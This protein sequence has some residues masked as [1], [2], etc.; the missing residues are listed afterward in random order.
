MKQKIALLIIACIVTMT[1][2][3]VIQGY[4]IY[5]TY[6]L[7]EREAKTLVT[8]K[9]LDVETTGKLDSINSKWMKKTGNFIVDYTNNRASKLDYLELIQKTED[10]LSKVMSDFIKMKGLV[11]DY[12]VTYSNYVTLVVLAKENTKEIDTLYKGQLLLFTNNYDDAREIKASE[13]R[14]SG[15]TKDVCTTAEPYD[16][17]VVTA[18]YYTISN[19]NSEVLWKMSGLLAFSVI[20]FALVIGLFYWSIKNLITQ[21]KIAD[22][23]TDFIN[24][25]THEFQTPLAALDI[26]VK[27]LK[28][29]DAELTPEQYNNSLAIIDRQNQRMQKLFGQVSEASVGAEGIDITKAELLGKEEIQQVID[30]FAISRPQAV[31]NFKADTAATIYIDRFHLATIL[32]NLLDNAVKY[33]AD[34]IDVSLEQNI[35]TS[36]LRIKDNGRGIAPKDQQAVFEKFYRVE[37]GNIHNTKGLGL[38][39]FYVKQIVTAYN[40]EITVKS[41]EQK[42]SIFTIVLPIA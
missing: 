16:F 14:W 34:V 24:N 32:N 6:Q 30:D 28:R 19:W 39:L 3:A 18:R 41:E 8:Q 13:S 7:R 33:G 4:F 23:K 42:G 38:G 12:D 20:L 27:T 36:G 2:L 40:G 29:K 26:A 21:K 15:T 35:S 17:A 37:K 9:L 25:I 1:A 22:V 5:N 31:I 11:E 10:S